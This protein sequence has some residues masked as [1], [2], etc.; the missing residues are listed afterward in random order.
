MMALSRFTNFRFPDSPDVTSVVKYLCLTTIDEFRRFSTSP[1][2]H[3]MTNTVTA[4]GYS[5]NVFSNDLNIAPKRSN[6]VQP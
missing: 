3:E 5:A 6:G 2:R 1:V 4:L